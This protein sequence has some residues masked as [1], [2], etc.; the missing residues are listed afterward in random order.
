MIARTQNGEFILHVRVK[1]ELDV[2]RSE[3]LLLVREVLCSFPW[4]VKP[5]TL[6]PTTR[7]RCDVS[8][9][10][11]YPGIKPRRSTSPIVT[12]FG[13][14]WRLGEYNKDLIS[15]VKEHSRSL[16]QDSDG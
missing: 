2:W 6:S 14:M 5:D 1:R 13:V 9:E 7:Y 16:I 3:T 11:R 15:L 10:L 4:P 8:S 12:R